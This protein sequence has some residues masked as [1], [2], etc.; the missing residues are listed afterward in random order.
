VVTLGYSGPDA[1]V[2]GLD[3]KVIQ[4]AGELVLADRLP[5]LAELGPGPALNCS[6]GLT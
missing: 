1:D 5:G 3:V 2:V 6:Q 4:E